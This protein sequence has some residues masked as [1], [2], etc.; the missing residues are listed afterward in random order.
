MLFTTDQQ[1]LD[2]LGIFGRKNGDS[3]FNQY[4]RAQTRGGASELEQMFRHPLSDQAAIARRSDIIRYFADAALAFPFVATQL[5]AAANYLANN[6]ERSRLDGGRSLSQKIGRLVAASGDAEQVY[7]GV[8]AVV[9]IL[10][11]A[12][13]FLQGM[14]LPASHAYAGEAGE[15]KGV[16]A[17]DALEPFINARKLTHE[18]AA[19]ADHVFRFQCRWQIAALLTAISRLDVYISIAGVARERRLTFATPLP[20]GAPQ[21][22]IRGVYHPSVKNAVAN[23]ITIAADGN[24]LFLTGANMAGKSTFMKTLSIALFVAHTGFPVA[25]EAMSFTVLDG[26]YTTINLPD[27]LGQGASHFYA[28]VMRVKKMALELATGKRLFIL[29]DELFRGTNV[30]DAYEATIAIVKGFAGKRES[31]FLISTHIVEA[32]PVL[33]QQCHNIRFIYL[34]TQ[35]Q[36]NRPVYPYKLEKGITSDRHGMVII[37]NEGIL[38]MLTSGLAV[39]QRNRL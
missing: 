28:E 8:Q 39:Q 27:N 25:A 4:N 22:N 17:T 10:G 11:T 36:G 38:D 5:D 16:L 2:D 29:F 9:S 3:V 20:P 1:T 26:M 21:V 23:D 13:T 31:I 12:Q 37:H 24:V 18:Q 7:S 30:K 15:M 6:D 34:P 35:M 14:V 32:G 19:E 33:E